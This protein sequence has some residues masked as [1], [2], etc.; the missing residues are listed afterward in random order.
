MSQEEIIK[1]ALKGVISELSPELQAAY[2]KVY[3]EFR[4]QI[5]EADNDNK[6]VILLAMTMLNLEY[7]DKI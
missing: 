7:K 5:E 1:L 3:K 4:I 6:Q 2:D